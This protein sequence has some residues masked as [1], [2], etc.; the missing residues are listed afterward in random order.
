M[1]VTKQEVRRHFRALPSSFS[2]AQFQQ[3]NALLG[4]HL[5]QSLRASPPESLVA[6]FRALTHEPKLDPLFREP[7][8]FCFPR[9][10]EGGEMK[11]YELERPSD[12]ESFT[13]GRFG[14]LEPKEGKLVSAAEIDICYIPLVA[15]DSLGYRL[16]QGQGYYDR[17]LREFEGLRIGVGFSWQESTAPLPIENHDERLHQVI[18]EKGIRE[19]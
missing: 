10:L 5:V 1:A 3:W 6:G 7:R 4:E 16:G 9:S 8:R 13:K 11:F 17:F 19:F 18:T 15:F 14:I 2:E 12:P